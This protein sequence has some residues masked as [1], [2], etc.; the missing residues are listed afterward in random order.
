MPATISFDATTSRE[1]A[2]LAEAEGAMVEQ[3]LNRYVLDIRR[4]VADRGGI[5]ALE[6]ANASRRE[7]ALEMDVPQEV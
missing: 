5:D 3:W 6:A 2:A 1:I 4:A 7:A